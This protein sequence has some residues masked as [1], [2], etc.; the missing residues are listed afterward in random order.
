MPTLRQEIIRIA[1]KHP[2]TRKHLVPL[3]RRTASYEWLTEKPF[4]WEDYKVSRDLRKYVE[5][6][7]DRYGGGGEGAKMLR[8]RT[9]KP[10]I[11]AIQ[12]G[13][14]QRLLRE[15]HALARMIIPDARKGKFEGGS[16]PKGVWFQ[17]M[18]LIAMLEEMTK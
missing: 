17:L 4:S 3:L 7:P 14:P 9:L 1:H 8:K 5:A 10:V 11:L 2:E 15:A 12:A 13:D 18:N 6:M 16:Y